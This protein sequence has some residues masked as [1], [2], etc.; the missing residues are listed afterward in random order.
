MHPCDCKTACHC[1][2][3][4]Q[5]PKCWRFPPPQ[6]SIHLFGSHAHRWQNTHS[7]PRTTKKH[8]PGA[9]FVTA[10]KLCHVA[11]VA[12]VHRALY[13]S[14]RSVAKW[15][16]NHGWMTSDDH[17][18]P[19]HKRCIQMISGPI[20]S[21]CCSASTMNHYQPPWTESPNS[22]GCQRRMRI[23]REWTKS[24]GFQRHWFGAPAIPT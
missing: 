12:T 9:S 17:P 5:R 13:S 16:S 8:M 7:Q 21:G 22:I 24:H 20:P 19:C 11:W 18:R 10:K 14:V 4:A 6:R 23:L 1:P 3:M 2:Q 15:S